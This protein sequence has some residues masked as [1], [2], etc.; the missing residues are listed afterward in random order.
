MILKRTAIKARALGQMSEDFTIS[1]GFKS[2]VSFII[3]NM[4]LKKN[5]DIE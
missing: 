1:R 2:M 4:V 3:L 5:K